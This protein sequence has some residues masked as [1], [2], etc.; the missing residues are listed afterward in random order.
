YTFNYW[1]VDN[2]PKETGENPTSLTMNESHT[3]TAHYTTTT[4]S[5]PSSPPS[6]P[7]TATVTFSQEGIG[8]DSNRT[9][10]T[11]DGLNYT[12]SQLPVT[13]TWN[14]GSSHSFNWADPVDTTTYGKRYAWNST[15]GLST[16]KSGTVTVPFGGGFVNA[17][18]K[19]QYYLEVS[20]EYGDTSTPSGWYDAGAN[21]TVTVTSPV[22]GPIG[23]RYVCIG[24]NGTGS[25]PSTGN[26]TAISFNLEEPSSITWNWKIQYYLRM[27]V[28]PEGSGMTTPNS[29]WYDAGLTVQ[30]LATPYS[31]YRFEGWTGLGLGSYSG[32]DPQANVTMNSPINETANFVAVAT[33]TFSVKGLA[34]DASGTVLTVDGA[35]YSYNQLPKSFTWDLGSV[36]TYTWTNTV[37]AEVAGKRYNWASTYGASTFQ[38]GSLTV[39]SSGEVTGNY[40]TI[41]LLEVLSQYGNPYGGGWYF[42]GQ[43]AEFGVSTPVDHG[44]RT[45]RVFVK[46]TG[47]L[48]L[49][50]PEGS[51]IMNKPCR[52]S[53]SWETQ[54]LITFNTTLPNGVVLSIPNVP[55]TLPP[56]MEVYG[57]YYPAYETVTVGPAPVTAP[58]SEGTRYA[59]KGW[60]MD[61]EKRTGDVVLKFTVD[62][63]HHVSVSYGVEHLLIVKALGVESP[64]SAR[65]TVQSSPPVEY[66]LQPTSPV[67]LWL[68]EG[69]HVTLT[70]STPNKIGHGEWAIFKE[71]TGKAQ[72]T[73]TKTSL[74]VLSP[75]TVNAVFFKVN[76]VALSIPYSITAGLIALVLCTLIVRR[77]KAEEHRKRRS[78]I[79]GITVLAVALIVAAIVSAIIAIGYGIN[80]YELPDI[81]NWAVVFTI[82][83]A[84]IFLLVSTTITWKVQRK[85]EEPKTTLK[86]T[87]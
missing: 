2:T 63:P 56:G 15:K 24:W 47:D 4:T 76:P 26:E 72:G 14:V 79:S 75:T 67:S 41:Y 65:L 10:L 5:P 82:I 69:V 28:K 74:I 81:T 83:E 77:K 73:Q 8:L 34:A 58:G 53:A 66:E 54:Y 71:W 43:E 21:I 59:F 12:V 86:T 45:I 29:G 20:S 39:S 25:V 33:I 51:I 60:D 64:F 3:A 70:V 38:N 32:T 35:S 27:D 44:N 23:T 84:I 85:P 55:T 13:F 62:G 7:T 11:V 37:N 50:N 1:E 49:Y 68:T 42:E 61:G 30:I 46:W 52:V 57:A 87:Q 31:G 78:A 22:Q 80:I 17:T 6:P 19:V 16:L 18:Y 36:H 40:K 48:E 9:V